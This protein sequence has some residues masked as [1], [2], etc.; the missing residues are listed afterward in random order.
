[1]SRAIGDMAAVFAND[2]GQSDQSRLTKA[3]TVLE[4]EEG[5]S[6]MDRAKLMIMA[7]KDSGFADLIISVKDDA[8]RRTIYDL[9]LAQ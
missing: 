5:L 6:T 4:K 8:T 9:Q 3:V 2:G 7:Q 1:M